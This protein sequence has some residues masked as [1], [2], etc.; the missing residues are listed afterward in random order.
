MAIIT[1][2]Y[3]L[4]WYG[5]CD[6]ESVMVSQFENVNTRGKLTFISPDFSG[7]TY[8]FARV[9]SSLDRL[10]CG[11]FYIV[12]NESGT[13]VDVPDFHIISTDGRSISECCDIS[14]PT[15]P[16]IIAP[17]ST[18][19]VASVNIPENTTPVT[20]IVASGDSP[21][22][23]SMEELDDSAKFNLNS[24]TGELTFKSPPDFETPTDG[25]GD[26]VYVVKVIATNDMGT[27]ELTLN[28]NVIDVDDIIT[29]PIPPTIILPGNGGSTVHVGVPENTT[30]VSVVVA[31]GDSPITYSIDS[32]GD[33]DNFVV[34]STSGKLTFKTAPDFENPI[35]QFAGSQLSP[36]TYLV[37][38]SATN[39]SGSDSI[40]ITVQVLDVP[41]GQM[42]C[43][44]DGNAEDSCLEVILK[45]G[46]DAEGYQNAAGIYEYN[47]ND[48]AYTN[49]EL[50]VDNSKPHWIKAD[51]SGAEIFF[52]YM[53]DHPSD[54]H[55]DFGTWWM[56]GP[57]S[58]SGP[59]M[60]W[61]YGPSAG[62][63]WNAQIPPYPWCKR[64]DQGYGLQSL[65]GFADVTQVECP[66]D[67]V[68]PCCDGFQY[69]HTQSTDP[70]ELGDSYDEDNLQ[71]GE[72]YGN[73]E[74]QKSKNPFYDD[75][76]QW[77][78]STLCHNGATGGVPA[79]SPID[80]RSLQDYF[81]MTDFPYKHGEIALGAEYTG[82]MRITLI[83]GDCYHACVDPEVDEILFVP[84]SETL[85]CGGS[86]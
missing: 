41:E 47:P 52:V 20:T 39:A 36:Y 3:T 49:T 23:Y 75:F 69:T 86:S 71:T 34:D 21:I 74:L 59:A 17:Q 24:T 53:E 63:P 33:S 13:D 5:G 77:N 50:P 83:N 46:Y 9:S 66:P 25:N 81:G 58:V 64:P 18:A 80:I 2:K 28:V 6:C 31:T 60:S 84:R 61:G 14:V 1:K 55:T 78:I 72:Q 67:V 73:V 45:A 44:I 37:R 27:D 11:K 70:E 15:P 29:I 42:E 4:G 43:S 57:N 48:S 7:S 16:T 35:E 54:D 22:T 56:A 65:W 19:N 68:I 51:G 82:E 79:R 30:D 62:P 85:N 12:S 32:Y 40:Q 26:N 76:P 38:V 10:S 8:Y